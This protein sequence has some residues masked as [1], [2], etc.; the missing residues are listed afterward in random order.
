L[1]EIHPVETEW[2]GSD[3][4]ASSGGGWKEIEIPIKI[5]VDHG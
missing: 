2:V 1:G 3:M 4:K 5:S